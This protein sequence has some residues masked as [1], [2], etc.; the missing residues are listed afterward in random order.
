[1]PWLRK[2]AQTL[3]VGALL[4]QP[5]IA[6]AQESLTG[7]IRTVVDGDT[8]DLQTDTDGLVRIRVWGINSCERGTTEGD[9]ATEWARERWEGLDVRCVVQGRDRFSRTVAVCY[10]ASS[11]ALSDI[12][13]PIVLA[14]HAH[15]VPHFSGGYYAGGP[16]VNCPLP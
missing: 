12:A 13:W 1:M 15:D 11:A 14:G 9:K 4:S 5:L 3:I 6:L 8:F 10:D 16:A 7:V 2:G